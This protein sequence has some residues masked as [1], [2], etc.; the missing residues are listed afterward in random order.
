[1]IS[2]KY[3][4]PVTFYAGARRPRKLQARRR[5]KTRAQSCLC[6]SALVLSF[7]TVTLPAQAQT[8]TTYT[9]DARGRAVAVLRSDSTSQSFVFD[10]ANNITSITSTAPGGGTGAAPICTAA[11]ASTSYAGGGWPGTTN[12]TDP[13]GDPLTVTVVSDPPGATTAAITNNTI[14][15]NAL[16]CGANALIRTVSDGNGND[17]TSTFTVTRFHHPWFAPNC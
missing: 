2:T 11:S 1:M 5:I 16:Q 7:V 15:M 10:D 6:V 3:A 12:C 13:D 4:F 17:V 9:Y 14:T 8:V